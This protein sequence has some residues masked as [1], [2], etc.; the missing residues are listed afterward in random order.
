MLTIEQCRLNLGVLL[1]ILLLDCVYVILL[2]AEEVFM[3]ISCV[4]SLFQ[5]LFA[6]HLAVGLFGVFLLR[7]FEGELENSSHDCHDDGDCY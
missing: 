4:F 2:F 5:T 3:F 7:T 1:E 6:V